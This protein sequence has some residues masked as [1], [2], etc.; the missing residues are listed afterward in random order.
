MTNQQ[1]LIGIDQRGFAL[2]IIRSLIAQRIKQRIPWEF[3]AFT[4]RRSQSSPAP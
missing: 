1:K 2:S 4:I 3:A